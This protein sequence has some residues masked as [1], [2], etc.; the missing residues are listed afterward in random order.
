VY[1]EGFRNSS[2]LP[3]V[4]LEY[5]DGTSNELVGGDEFVEC[6]LQSTAPCTCT[7]QCLTLLYTLLTSCS[8][9]KLS[10]YST[11]RYENRTVGYTYRSVSWMV[12]AHSWARTR[13]EAGVRRERG[14]TALEYGWTSNH[15]GTSSCVTTADSSKN[16]TYGDGKSQPFHIC[17]STEN[18]KRHNLAGCTKSCVYSNYCVPVNSSAGSRLGCIC[19]GCVRITVRWNFVALSYSDGLTD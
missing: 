6:P 12:C 13:P 10:I 17:L 1:L 19:A 16:A 11:L 8:G 5:R 2:P 14:R 15:G 4:D 3:Q 9:R 18:D 7:M